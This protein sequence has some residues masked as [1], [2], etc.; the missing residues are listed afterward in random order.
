[1]YVDHLMAEN[2]LPYLSS[3]CTKQIVC[4]SSLRENILTWGNATV[5]LYIYLFIC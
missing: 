5:A 4:D 3:L 1:M 2:L